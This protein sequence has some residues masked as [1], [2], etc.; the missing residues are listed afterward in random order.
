MHGERIV[1]SASFGFQSGYRG[2]P[3]QKK[4]AQS[5]HLQGGS[6]RFPVCSFLKPRLSLQPMRF[7]RFKQFTERGRQKF[8]L[9]VQTN[10]SLGL[11]NLNQYKTLRL[12]STQSFPLFSE[13][14]SQPLR[15]QP[16]CDVG[17]CDRKICETIFQLDARTWVEHSA[18]PEIVRNIGDRFCC[19][20]AETKDFVR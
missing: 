17:V 2:Q 15:C 1:L 3:C 19:A 12:P 7:L 11:S 16:L 8:F 14:T 6:G 5:R 13:L 9:S 20:R 4:T 10:S 18:A